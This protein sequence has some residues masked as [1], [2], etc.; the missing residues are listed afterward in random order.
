MANLDKLFTPVRLGELELANRIVMAPMTRNRADDKGEPGALMVEYYAQRAGAGLIV[1]EGTWPSAVGQAYCRQPGIATAEQVAA[2]RKVTDAVHARGGRIVLQIMHAGRIGS[3]HIKGKSVDTVAP[4][5]IRAAGEVFTDSA[6]M[7]PFDEPR[8]LSTEEV[9]AIVAEHRQAA[10]NARE[11]GFD[12]VEL[13]C[14]S[15]YISQQFMSTGSNQRTDEYGGSVANRV[16]FPVE[17]LRA[18]AEAIGAG[19]VGFRCRV[20]NTFNDISDE[21][22]VATHGELMRQTAGMGLAYA[23]V[24][25]A[26]PGI[27]AF[28]L[29]REHF[30]SPLIL[31]DDFDGGS[32]EAALV[33]G[34]GE[35]I[36]FGRHFIANPDLPRRLRDGLEL[37]RFDRRSLYTAGEQGYTDYPAAEGGA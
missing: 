22:S 18:M 12:G 6:G 16:R 10:L 3:H 23:H 28:A 17:C 5:A 1:A 20:G 21:D 4:S 37:A 14:T 36:A 13:H 34:Q 25:R 32:A 11:A 2:W 35:A 19:R 15:G 26:D 9:R 7:Q 24:M 30:G 27:D 31:S 29:A 33:A 8:A